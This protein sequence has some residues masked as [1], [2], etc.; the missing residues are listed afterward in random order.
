L[1]DAVVVGVSTAIA[2]D[3]MLTVRHC[4]GTHPVR[5]VVDP[6][7]RLPDHARVLCDDGVGR[8]VIQAGRQA[9]PHGVERIELPCG[10]DGIAPATILAAL[11][12]R[13]LRRILIEGGAH[14]LSRFLASG[15]LNRLHV[16]LAPV[17]LG[18]GIT[19]I[20]LP[21][22]GDISHAIRPRMHSY[23]LPDGDILLDC[24]LGH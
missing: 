20:D 21:A 1:V 4:D 18:S 11:H 24:D 15:R 12:E 23:A 13:G 19:G 6:W 5:V 7:G 17:I 14:T 16:L 8:I 9:R 22:I 3:P 10:E 2:D